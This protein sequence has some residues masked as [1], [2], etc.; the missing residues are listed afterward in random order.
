MSTILSSAA[1]ANSLAASANAVL[2]VPNPLMYGYCR[3]R[4]DNILLNQLTN[5][6]TVAFYIL[7]EGPWDGIERLWIGKKLWNIADTTT[8]HF[9]PGLDGILG[10]GLTPE[11]TGGDQKVDNFFTNIPANF[12]P[13]TYSRKA[14]LAV[15]VPPD[16]QSPDANLDVLGDYRTSQIRI[17]DTN[18]NQTAFQFSTNP[19][20]QVLDLILRTILNPEWT[21]SGAQAG[22]GDLT[23]QQKARINFA[24]VYAAAQWCDTV[25]SN[26]QKRFESSAAFVQTMKLQQALT[27]LCVMGQLYVTEEGG[28]I[29]IQADQPRASTFT[30][31]ADHVVAGTASFDKIDTHGAANRIMAS[32]NDLNAQD[33]ADID[34]PAN[35]GLSR[36]SN[37]VT[38]KFLGAHP[39]AVGDQ[40]QI[41]PPTDGSTHDTSFDGVFPVAT[42]PDSTHITYAQTASN[43]TS[44][45]GYAGT[46]ESRFAQRSTQVDHLRHQNAIGARGLNLNSLYRRLPLNLI[47]GNNTMERV[48]RILNFLK[49]RN[50]GI[51]AV[52]GAYSEPWKCKI[53]AYINAV[54]AANNV[55]M[56]QLCGDIVTVDATISDEFQGNYEILKKTINWPGLNDGTSSIAGGGS[57]AGGKAGP[58]IVSISLEM[59]QYLPGAFSDTAPTVQKLASS[60]PRGNLP[61][62]LITDNMVRNGD[63]S[64]GQ[65]NWGNGELGPFSPASVSMNVA[66]LPKGACEL[67]I[68]A[69]NYWCSVESQ[70]FIAIDKNKIYLIEAWLKIATPLSGGIAAYG[71]FVEYDINKNF[72]KHTASGAVEAYAL[73][74]GITSTTS[75]GWQYFS[76]EVTG[77]GGTTAPSGTQFNS[78]TAYI[79]LA[80][81]TQPGT[82]TNEKLEVCG[83]RLSEVA[84]GSARAIAGLQSGSGQLK[85]TFKNNSVNSNGTYTGANPLS[86]SGTTTTINVAAFSI[87]FGDGTVS[88][89]SG[90]VNPGAYGTY[91]VYTRDPTFSGGAVTYFATQTLSDLSAFNDV[92]YLGKIATAGGGGGAGTGGGGGGGSCFSGNTSVRVP[93]QTLNLNGV[94]QFR[95][96]PE[97]LQIMTLFGARW[98][99]VRRRWYDGWMHEM[100]NAELVTPPHLIAEDTRLG[101]WVWAATIWPSRVRWA[102]YVYTLEVETEEEIERHFIL[103]NGRIAHNV[104]NYS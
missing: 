16:P 37:V 75:N 14:Y 99:R 81:S 22:G 11:S 101:S 25:L 73:A 43:A 79:R 4:G 92:I 12:Q 69:G 46:P 93:V 47:L 98:A 35:S 20:W 24:A 60:P 82:G 1:A 61:P 52:G 42:V 39:F 59:L 80:F 40:V 86:Q 102:G 83:V 51:D 62:A 53:E 84:A 50:L 17:F 96:M 3:V 55:L 71:A 44:G 15:N 72:V 34:T 90:S 54:D 7:G 8:V 68:P 36:S 57:G 38:V 85:G 23:A 48:T 9:H 28:Q 29:Y 45:N 63:F 2:G 10:H 5:K 91:Y 87:K 41:C 58:G 76:A 30:L 103:A 89:N 21:V 100:G 77:D 31:T 95:D 70:E 64:L 104:S 56:A 32:F 78:N 27:Q 18:G 97:R 49:N 66:S 88:Y 19:A 94:L 13:L 26:N 33:Q 67:V 74:S 6:N 65:T